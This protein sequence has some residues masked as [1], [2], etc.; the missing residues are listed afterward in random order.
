MGRAPGTRDELWGEVSGRYADNASGN[1]TAYVHREDRSGVYYGTELDRL[2]RN[3]DVTRV[4]QVDPAPGG[5]TT[6]P[7]GG[8]P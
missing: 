7:V 5:A 3:P 4:T 6:Y 8:P 2:G 1:V